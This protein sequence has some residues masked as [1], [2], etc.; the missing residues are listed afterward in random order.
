MFVVIELE[1]T[2]GRHCRVTFSHTWPPLLKILVHHV[3]VSQLAVCE[4]SGVRQRSI[5]RRQEAVI[6]LGVS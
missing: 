2:T 3:M 1:N 5:F 4:G 6:R